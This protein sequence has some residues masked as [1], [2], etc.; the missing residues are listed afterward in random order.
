MYLPF[1]AI[2]LILIPKFL[3]MLLDFKFKNTHLKLY[4]GP[5]PLTPKVKLD[6]TSHTCVGSHFITITFE[7][8]IDYLTIST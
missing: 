6:K 1:L 8:L 5:K 2:K 4:T 3:G 7:I